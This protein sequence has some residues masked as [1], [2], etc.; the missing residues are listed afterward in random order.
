MSVL[1]GKEIVLKLIPQEKPMCMVDTLLEHDSQ[2]T[3]TAF[4]IDQDNIFVENGV[5]TE[6]GLIENM[7]QSAA[8]RTGWVGYQNKKDKRDYSPLIGVIGAVK[9]FELVCLPAVNTEIQTEVELLAEFSNASMIKA[10]VRSGDEVL[11]TCELKIFIQEQ[12][13]A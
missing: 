12:Q 1:A 8:L 7:A 9:N 6:A 10:K 13:N 2:K 11:A 4:T 3:L 5:F